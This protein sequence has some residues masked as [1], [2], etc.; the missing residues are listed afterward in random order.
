MYNFDGNRPRKQGSKYSL[1]LG[2][3]DGPYLEKEICN[4]QRELS[5]ATT[6]KARSRSLPK[7]STGMRST[8][9]ISS[10]T[11]DFRESKRPMPEMPELYDPLA[12]IYENIDERLK[13]TMSAADNVTD[14]SSYNEKIIKRLQQR[15]IEYKNI[16]KE[17][18]QDLKIMYDRLKDGFSNETKDIR[19]MM[20]D[21]VQ[22]MKTQLQLAKN[23]NYL[24]EREI[25]ELHRD[26][27]RIQRQVAFCEK[28]VIELEEAVGIDPKAAF[29]HDSEETEY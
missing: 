3:N 27:S 17:Y 23:E 24:R 28:R 10:Q 20:R 12:R 8:M 18:K 14:Q 15:V 11:Y 1:N 13:A 25:E 6:M 19:P 9:G 29:L 26:K 16:V 21:F 5:I 7:I 22:G 2:Q 4:T